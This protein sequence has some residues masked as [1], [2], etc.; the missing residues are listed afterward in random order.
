M[1][2]PIR[3]GAGPESEYSGGATHVPSIVDLLFTVGYVDGL[4]HPREQAFVRQYLDSVVLVIEQSAAA[5]ERAGLRATWRARFDELYGRLDTEVSALASGG[6]HDRVPTSLR[7]RALGLFRSLPGPDQMAAI[8]L[9]YALIHADGVITGAERTLYEELTACFAA[10]TV[11]TPTTPTVRLAA[12][13]AAPGAGSG[14]APL[15]APL[16][17]G[18][19]VWH[20]LVACAHP[21]LDPIEQTYSPHP[22]ERKA[23]I[24]W[25][26]QLVQLAIAQW[27]RQRAA[28]AGGLAGFTDIAQVPV[29]SRFLDGYVHV[30]RPSQP[31]ELV[32]LGDLHGCYSCLKAV[33]L[34]SNFIQRAWAHQWDPERYPD[35]KLVLLGDYIDRGLFSFDGVL[36]AVLHL[37]VSMPD[38][39]IVLRGN[40]E[41][42]QWVGNRIV[43]GVYPAEALASI[44]PYV[45]VEMLEAYR[46]LFEHMPT[47]FLCDRTMF[48]HGGIPRDDTFEARYRDLS[49]LNDPELRF[50]MMWSDPVTTDLVPV[51]MQRQNPRFMFGRKQFRSF[52]ERA[53]LYTMIR[54]HEK[55]DRGFD[56]FYNLGE[57]LLLNL[58]SAGGHDN[59]DLPAGSSYRSVT[60]M[61][62][63]IK[64]DHGVAPTANPWP[65]LYQA[66]NYPPHNG[67]YRPQPVL[68]FRYT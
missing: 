40:H 42:L 47:S 32:V 23:Q 15:A 14:A 57:H 68:E 25:D 27:Q 12:S 8:E 22:V 2:V 19:P 33:L 9:V 39:V 55:I 58:F 41:H 44:A 5:D 54:G 17:L 26:Y 3:A 53:G 48:V 6:Q 1:E 65:L 45:P 4:F 43:S 46:R 18:A 59:C 36:R 64:Y 21:L 56:V 38:H 30:L 34:Q 10:V 63:T 60:P 61:A 66:F 16:V 62:L 37:F 20:D 7:L 28:G 35:I 52:M 49:S 29:G 13:A 50:Q 11:V 31:V 51:D 24:D 67:F